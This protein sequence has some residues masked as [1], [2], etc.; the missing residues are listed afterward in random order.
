MSNP[1]VAKQAELCCP[2]AVRSFR[3]LENDRT[4]RSVVIEAI[5]AKDLDAQGPLIRQ[6]EFNTH[7]TKLQVTFCDLRRLYVIYSLAAMFVVNRSIKFL[8][9]S[10]K[11]PVENSSLSIWLNYPLSRWRRSSSTFPCRFARHK[12]SKSFSCVIISP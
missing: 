2:E 1:L 4:L 3:V 8:S 9:I 7:V 11:F 12:H 5:F 10:L 6:L